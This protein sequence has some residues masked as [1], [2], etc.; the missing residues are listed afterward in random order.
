MM[1]PELSVLTGSV[2]PPPWSLVLL[3]LSSLSTLA[4]RA[5]TVSL[6][7]MLRYSIVTSVSWPVTGA[8]G[9]CHTLALVQPNTSV[10][11]VYH[12]QD[13]LF[14]SGQEDKLMVKSDGSLVSLRSGADSDSDHIVSL[15]PSVNIVCTGITPL[16]MVISTVFIVLILPIIISCISL[17]L[18]FKAK[19]NQSK[20]KVFKN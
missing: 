16:I 20:E 11:S 2:T 5:I 7:T 17:T 12:R 1:R 18:A 19:G 14:L 13:N 6:V 8:V 3:T 10:V 9:E 4:T 15:P